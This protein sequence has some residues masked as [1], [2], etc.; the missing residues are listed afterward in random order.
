[1]KINIRIFLFLFILILPGAACSA[2]TR[3]IGWSEDGTLF[4]YV[5]YYLGFEGDEGYLDIQIVDMVSDK[6]LWG[7]SDYWFSGYNARDGG[8]D[9]DIVPFGL[10]EALKS[11]SVLSSIPGKYNII[12][13]E[14]EIKSL[15]IRN[16]DNKINIEFWKTGTDAYQLAAVRE[17]DA[18]II[19]E[20]TRDILAY[21]I[22]GYYLN[23]SGTRAA[24]IMTDSSY[25]MQPGYFKVIGCHLDYGFDKTLMINKPDNEHGRWGK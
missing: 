3:C 21:N 13:K 16:G 22:S 25:F 19:S 10:E 12:R 20:G 23:P 18:K 1:M 15:P 4:C 14:S 6:V 24:I 2:E 7:N 9:G 11:S 17:N 5:S 8:Y